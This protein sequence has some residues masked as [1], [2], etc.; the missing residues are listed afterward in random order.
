MT[1]RCECTGLKFNPEKCHIK[2]RKIKFYGTVCSEEGVQPHPTQVLALK[3]M[4]A[5]EDQ[6]ELPTFLGLATFIPHL[7]ALTAPLRSLLKKD[8]N[9][10]WNANCQEAFEQIKKSISSQVTL[11]YFD[12]SQKV[13]LHVYASTK[14]LGA[15]LIQDDKS[16]AF[17]SKALTET[18]TRYVNIEREL[19][20]VMYGCERFHTYLFG[21]P[22]VV[23]SDHKPLESIH[24]KHLTSSD[25]SSIQP[26][27]TRKNK[28]G[29][30]QSS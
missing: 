4:K 25:I 11:C 28:G 26:K 9:F 15:A 5:P 3:Q 23:E 7:S 18:K 20:A 19:P 17:A 2:Q 10:Q 22:S 8:S 21:H 13:T 24:L 16:I 30:Q 29:N 1:H 12:K 14:G 6:R 27:H